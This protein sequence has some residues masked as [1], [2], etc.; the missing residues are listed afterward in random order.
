MLAPT[1]I[2]ALAPVER[3]G[4]GSG[5]G[6]EEDEEEGSVGEP[7]VAVGFVE[8]WVGNGFVSNGS[9][10]GIRLRIEGREVGM[11]NAQ[12]WKKSSA[13]AVQE[14]EIAASNRC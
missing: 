11:N 3:E 5:V 7:D 8:D 13:Q 14:T 2:P 4:A 10:K 12:K 9:R 1:A 6:V